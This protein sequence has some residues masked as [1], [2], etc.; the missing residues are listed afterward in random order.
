LKEEINVKDIEFTSDISKFQRVVVKPNHKNLGPK[1][2]AQAKA[3]AE[4]I[5]AADADALLAQFE[6]DGAVKLAVGNDAVDIMKGDTIVETAEKEGYKV[7]SEG[8]IALVLD[9][10]MTDALRSEGMARE[11][12]RRI[13][14]M[15]K[16]INFNLEDFVETTIALDEKTK[17]LVEAQKD[18]IASETRS[19]ALA[20]GAVDE[21]ESDSTIVR[22]WN[23]DGKKIKIGVKCV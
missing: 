11:L 7:A 22:E 6:S 16:T 2:R 13:Q 15:R 21:K 23:I 20:F 1:F 5:S 19:K 8:D 9:I 12:I 4:A 14:E 3:I 18:L 10:T 17:A